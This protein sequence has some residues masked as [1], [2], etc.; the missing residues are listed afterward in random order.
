MS[1]IAIGRYTGS[2]YPEGKGFTGVLHLGTKP[3]GS[4]NR[5]KRKGATKTIVREKLVELANDIDNK[6][7]ASRAHTV[8][9]VVTEYVDDLANEG[10]APATI[11][12]YRSVIK[13]HV[14]RIGSIK[15][16][17][18]DSATVR[19]WLIEMSG[20]LSPEVLRKVHALLTNAINRAITFEYVGRN[21]SMPVKRPKGTTAGLRE[22]KSFTVEQ[23][24][25]ILTT[26]VSPFQRM[27]GY[28]ALALTSGLR[29]DELNGLT[30]RWLELDA[31]K[32]AVYV[33]RAARTDG[34]LKTKQS[35]RGL[36]LGGI[37]VKALKIWQERQRKEFANLGMEVTEDTPVF[38]LPDGCA[39]D[40]TRARNEFRAL[41]T[42]AGIADATE[43][44]LRETRT[45][46]VSVMSH[47]GIGRD[48]IAAMCGH[49]LKI[50]ER[51]YL[52]VLAPVHAESA[53]LIDLVFGKAA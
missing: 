6:V 28:V 33:E 48:K 1:R 4:L 34:A 46:F 35:R 39:Y 2:I 49:S 38:T 15:I 23:T 3:D 20:K 53:E 29:T 12:F 31:A 19:D 17:D 18:L 44:T 47:K 11:R 30:W 32:P 41:L 8:L 14:K 24:E 13:C 21:V 50:L 27:G 5:P 40:A 45:T 42:V 9:S 37:A 43:W 22:S 10:K 25:A 52:K 16:K 51:H 36:L 26:C 7:K